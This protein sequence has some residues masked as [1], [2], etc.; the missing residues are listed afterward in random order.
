MQDSTKIIGLMNEGFLKENSVCHFTLP[1][2][3]LAKPSFFIVSLL[4]ESWGWR[5]E[6][7]ATRSGPRIKKRL[8]LEILRCRGPLV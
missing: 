6:M 2:G 7:K 5:R 1:V 4:V 8:I 3:V